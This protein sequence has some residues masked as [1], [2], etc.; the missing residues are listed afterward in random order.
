MPNGV[1]TSAHDMK[2]TPIKGLKVY[3]ESESTSLILYLLDLQ[4]KISNAAMKKFPI[5]ILSLCIG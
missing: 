1:P 3:T 4:L 5:L 2:D